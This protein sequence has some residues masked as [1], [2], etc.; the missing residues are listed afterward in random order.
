MRRI[1]TFGIAVMAGAGLLQ[2]A[3]AGSRSNAHSY[4]S[5]PRY[6]APAHHYSGPSRSYAPA[7][8]SSAP[9]SYPRSYAPSGPRF[10]SGTSLRNSGYVMNRARFSGNRSTAFNTRTNPQATARLAPGVTRTRTPSLNNNRERVIGRYG[11]NWRRN[12]DRRR[13]HWWHGRRCHFHNNVWIIYEPFFWYPSSYGYGYYPS[14]SYYDDAYYDD[15]SA[16]SPATS[17][18]QPE[19][20][21]GSR[22]SEVQT[23]LAREG[24][25]DGPID[26]RLGSTTRKALRRYQSDHG[27]EVTGTVSRALIEALQLR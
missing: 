17:A 23:A 14:S 27:L 5:A 12:W 11:A 18:N 10:S 15:G 25:Y 1:C 20:E 24:Y 9:R 7:R 16:S 8:F 21:T 4:S 22:V 3:Q 26:G 13:D 2:P 6:S 19:Y